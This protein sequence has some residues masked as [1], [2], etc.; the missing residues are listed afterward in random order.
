L[1]AEA[2]DRSL[3]AAGIDTEAKKVDDVSDLSSYDGVV[4][5]R[6]VYMGSWI[7]PA[8]RFVEDH[9]EELAAHPTWL[10]SRGPTGDPP[11]PGGGNGRRD[12]TDRGAR[13]AE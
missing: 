7:E 4:L 12:R 10:F 2:I 11:R 13:Q 3:A 5:G 6:P 1:P 9:A 8:R